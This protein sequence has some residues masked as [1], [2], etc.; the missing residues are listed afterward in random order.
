MVNF[1]IE[2]TA[3]QASLNSH[4]CGIS[5]LYALQKRDE[6]SSDDHIYGAVYQ[7]RRLESLS[8]FHNL[9]PQHS[10]IVRD[11]LNEHENGIELFF[12]PLYSQE[13]NPD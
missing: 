2:M 9:K 13:L 5:A 11:W 12:L 3:H 8:I 7:R 4:V 6:F 10:H 1:C